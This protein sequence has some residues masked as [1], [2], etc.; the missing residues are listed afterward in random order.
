[1][2]HRHRTRPTIASRS[3]PNLL[4]RCIE[5]LQR[6]DDEEEA[7][8]A[9]FSEALGDDHPLVLERRQRALTKQAQQPTKRRQP[10]PTGG[11]R[12]C[13]A[14]A[15]T[16]K[17][18]PPVYIIIEDDDE[19]PRRTALDLAAGDQECIIIDDDDDDQDQ[20]DT[21]MMVEHWSPME[22]A[23][24]SSFEEEDVQSIDI[25][26]PAQQPA[27][28]FCHAQYQSLASPITAAEFDDWINTM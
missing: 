20:D 23:T 8:T 7:L 1:M 22:S 10:V 14:P 9:Q 15:I 25:E 27:T 2:S 17:V 21:D 3:K 18:A 24:T 5:E 19:A 6:L 26:E 12:C 4:Q 11:D 28:H 13:L 16:K